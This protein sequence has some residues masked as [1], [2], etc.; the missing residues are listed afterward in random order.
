M[1]QLLTRLFPLS[2]TCGGIIALLLLLTPILSRRFTPRWRYWAWL[3][4]A[5]RLVLPF[6]FSWHPME[7]SIPA[8]LTAPSYDPQMSSELEQAYSYGWQAGV[9]GG[10]TYEVWYT[11]DQ[12]REYHIFD[13][14]LVRLE[15]VNGSWSASFRWAYIWAAGGMVSLAWL[16]L[17]YL[18][19]CRQLARRRLPASQEEHKELERQRLLLSVTGSVGLFQVPGLA[20]PM[21]MGFLRPTVLIPQDLPS[22]ALPVALAHELQH[23]K[24]RD[25][26]YKLLLSLAGC[27]HWF[28]PLVWLMIRQGGQDVELCCDY[29]LLKTRDTKA[30]RAYGRAILEQMTVGNSKLSRLTTGFSG[31]K[32]EIFARFRAMMDTS[33]KGSGRGAIVLILAVTVLAGG[34]VGCQTQMQRY[35]QSQ[36]DDVWITGIDLEERTVTYYPLSPELLSDDQAL[37][38]WLWSGSGMGAEESY[39]APLGEDAQ[40]LHTFEGE[41]YP[42]N[43]ATILYT[44]HMTQTGAQG[45]V[46]LDGSG[47]AVLVQL[48][49]SS[50]LDLS[51]P[52]LDFSGYCGTVYA[53]GME[54]AHLLH[55]RAALSV[56]PCDETGAD[57]DHTYYALP[58][59]QD[60]AVPEEYRDFLT[61]LSS[62]RYP[63]YWQFTV[64][65][66]EVTAVE[67]M[68][69][70]TGNGE[71]FAETYGQ[72]NGTEEELP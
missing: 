35:N 18:R 1:A 2:L 68:G 54:G 13:L 72:F 42:L 29:D 56:D 31:N 37:E 21:L 66:G 64:V 25:L 49:G 30:R 47:S 57:S 46:V 14:A 69:A 44:L 5:V 11:D 17:G 70:A 58:L 26:W 71:E 3:F 61:G 8:S 24:R 20:S 34:L 36:E 48:A 38:E 67:A 62:A 23:L 40:L 63:N 41:A 7:L 43:P 39:T 12:Q 51:A 33:P 60:A 19:L 27:I 6:S 65:N 32:K 15:G 10:A 55:G 4:V 28:N 59:S 45:R 53:A 22:A 16:A 50:R 52:D 9:A